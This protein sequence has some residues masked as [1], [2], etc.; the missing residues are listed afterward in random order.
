MKCG[1]SSVIQPVSTAVM[2]MPSVSN[3]SRALVRVSMFSAA[4]AILVCGCP[5]PLYP[6]PKTP[7]IAETLTMYFRRAGDAAIAGR[8]RLTSRKGAVMFASCTSS[9]SSGST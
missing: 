3:I 1:R 2:R 8:S 4:F 9:I 5:G 7:S 6:R